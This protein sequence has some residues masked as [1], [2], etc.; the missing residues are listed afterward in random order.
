MGTSKTPEQFVGK[1]NESA[2]RLQKERRA[3]VDDA[4]LV[5]KR[6]IEGSIRTVVP[7]MNMSGVGRSGV[8]VGVRYDIKGTRNPTSLIRA[9]GPLH[10]VENPTSP[11]TIP[12]AR[13]RRKVL[14][15]G[16]GEFRRTVEHPGTRGQRPF[17][18]GRE[19]GTPAAKTIIERS[20]VRVLRSVFR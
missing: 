8:K 7:D 11:H 20:T 15:F 13:R 18:K 12:K 5:M 2:K 16:D 10:L 9:T 17:R 1:I 14:K 3:I 6:A 4:S 19:L